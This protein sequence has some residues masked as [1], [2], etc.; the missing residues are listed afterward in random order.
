MY[1]YI[2]RRWAIGYSYAKSAMSLATSSFL[3]PLAGGLFEVGQL[4]RYAVRLMAFI[5]SE[6]G[7]A[8]SIRH[9]LFLSRSERCA[10]HQCL[11]AP[12]CCIENRRSHL[13]C[14]SSILHVVYVDILIVHGQ[15][16]NCGPE[17]GW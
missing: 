12:H 5:S 6:L 7:T 10:S 15:C 14:I 1:C 3:S 9:E 17:E 2:C 16:S 8:E 11:A 13:V 4:I